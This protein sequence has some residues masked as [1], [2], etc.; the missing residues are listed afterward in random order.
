MWLEEKQE[1]LGSKKVVK[2]VIFGIGIIG[3][4]M[5]AKLIEIGKAPDYLADNNP[6]LWNTEY[7]GIPIVS[8]EE[9]KQVGPVEII[10]ACKKLNHF[11]QF[12][13]DNPKAPILPETAA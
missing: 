4:E 9:I 11:F 1:S 3:K 2:T 5:I 7:K 6:D 10:I 13:T 12:E 8:V